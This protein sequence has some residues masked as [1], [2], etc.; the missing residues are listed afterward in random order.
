M[1]GAHGPSTARTP[2]YIRAA[3][4]KRQEAGGR[5]AHLL[6]DEGHVGVRLQGALQGDVAGRTSHEP[7]EVVVLLGRDGVEAHVA[8]GVRGPRAGEGGRSSIHGMHR[9]GG[10]T[11]LERA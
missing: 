7:N 10:C 4:D 5:R 2:L 6:S 11:N 9:V 1:R 3:S 8:C